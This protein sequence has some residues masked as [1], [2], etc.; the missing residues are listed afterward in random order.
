MRLISKATGGV[1]EAEGEAAAKLI[2]SG[3]FVADKPKLAPKPAPKPKG[4]P[5]VNE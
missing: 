2:E 1:V 3:A 4:K 5:K